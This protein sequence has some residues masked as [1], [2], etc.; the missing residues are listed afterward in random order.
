M[1]PSRPFSQKKKINK[2]S[3]DMR[4]LFV[5]P[6]RSQNQQFPPHPAVI[7]TKPNRITRIIS[8]PTHCHPLVCDHP[9]F[10]DCCV[11]FRRY[12]Y[13]LREAS[14]FRRLTR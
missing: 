9:S 2:I 7:K 1:L 8:S 14:L 4:A 13:Y 10:E 11:V 6:Q 12:M 3:S 5:T